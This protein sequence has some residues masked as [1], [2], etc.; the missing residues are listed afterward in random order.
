M[1]WLRQADFQ[2]ISEIKYARDEVDRLH[3]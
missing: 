1:I 3:N 2:T